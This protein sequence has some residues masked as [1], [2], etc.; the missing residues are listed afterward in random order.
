MIVRPSVVHAVV[1]SAS[2]IGLTLSVAYMALY[3]NAAGLWCISVHK[4]VI[5]MPFLFGVAIVV[6]AGW[7][8]LIRG[9]DKRE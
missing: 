9:K 2:A 4:V 6:S 5:A 8:A 1:S 3:A 7:G